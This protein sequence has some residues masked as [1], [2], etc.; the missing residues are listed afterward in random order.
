MLSGSLRSASK[1]VHL[2]PILKSSL[3]AVDCWLAFLLD[4]ANAVELMGKPK[5]LLF[6]CILL[7]VSVLF[8]YLTIF[9]STRYILEGKELEFYMKKLQRKKGKATGAAA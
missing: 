5:G 7:F 9:F 8:C 6:F 1:A 2:I 4:Q 3:G